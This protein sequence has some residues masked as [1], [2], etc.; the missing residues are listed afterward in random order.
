[1]GQVAPVMAGQQWTNGAV[2]QHLAPSEL[3]K[4]AEPR[5]RDPAERKHVDQIAES[6]KR[7][8]Y[9]VRQHDSHPSRPDLSSH[10]RLYHTDEGSFLSNGN[11]RVAALVRSGYSKKVPVMV[12]DLRS[13]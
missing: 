7:Q 5:D 1:M 3:A 11:H 2:L 13:G 9:R 12:K 8:G 6:I 4:Y 10:I